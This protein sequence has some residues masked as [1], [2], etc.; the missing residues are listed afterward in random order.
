MNQTMEN[1]LGI[2]GQIV[3]EN[4]YFPTKTEDVDQ[5]SKVTVLMFNDVSK[6][7][8]LKVAALSIFTALSQELLETQVSQFFPLADIN[9]N[10]YLLIIDTIMP[11]D[12]ISI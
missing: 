7:M 9:I 1:F 12:A 4:Y 6:V 2:C 3:G 8:D 5:S 10:L 11:K